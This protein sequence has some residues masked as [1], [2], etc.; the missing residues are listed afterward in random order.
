MRA[1]TKTALAAALSA[2]VLSLGAD[3][4]A[5][6]LANTPDI[7][8]KLPALGYEMS[9]E[10]V[11]GTMKLY[12]PLHAA[13]DGAGVA[14][15]SAAYGA[16]ERQ[17]LD[18]YAPAS[19]ANGAPVVLFAHGGGFVRGDKK[20]VANIG[21]YL[22]RHGIVAATLNYRFAPEAQWPAGG[23]DMALA[24]VWLKAN[25]AALGG[26]PARMIVAGNSAGSMHAADYAFREEL[27]NADDGVIGAILISP[28][29][30]DLTA[31]PVDPKR[32]A[33]YYGTDG[34]RAAQSV[35]NAVEGRAL[36]VL[37]AYAEHEPAVII[38]QT[39]L[40]IAALTRRDGRL[41]LIASAPGHNHISV[42]EHIGTADET[43]GPDLVEFV[44]SLAGG[45]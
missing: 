3:P 17:V 19:G 25:V 32:D 10:M 38:D 8:A 12:K 16:H 45:R 43:L 29:T 22:A 7:A 14:V 4:A 13:D 28:P 31:R 34:D 9:R 35:V 2:I 5:A 41:P 15:S 30:A 18:V 1:P 33:L 11:G 40:M 37:V 36:P 20:A 6:Q 23:E 21:R 27:Q 44:L 24:L 26:D 42:V 39:R